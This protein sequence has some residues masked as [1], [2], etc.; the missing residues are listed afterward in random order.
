MTVRKV[1]QVAKK[2]KFQI[3]LHVI[4]ELISGRYITRL[5]AIAMR[6]V[7]IAKGNSHGDIQLIDH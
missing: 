2:L 5:T 1:E 6:S 3:S 4:F 7:L